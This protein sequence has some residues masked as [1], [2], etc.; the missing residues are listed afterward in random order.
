MCS[1]STVD[2]EIL[3]S[4][5]RCYSFIFT[6]EIFNRKE[7]PFILH[8]KCNETLPDFTVMLLQF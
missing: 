3:T 2:I 7:P 5:H 8:M 1:T 4:I 6:I